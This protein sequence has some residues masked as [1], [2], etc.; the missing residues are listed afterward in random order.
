MS[1]GSTWPA[2]PAGRRRLVARRLDVLRRR[3][4]R[5]GRRRRADCQRRHHRHRNPFQHTHRLRNSLLD[6]TILLA[7]PRS[8]PIRTSLRRRRIRAARRES[9]AQA[10]RRAAAA[11]LAALAAGLAGLVRGPLVGGALLMR[12][13]AAL[14]GDFPLLLRGHR[15]E[16]AA[17]LAFPFLLRLSSISCM[18]ALAGWPAVVRAPHT[19][20][21]RFRRRI[22]DGRRFR[23]VGRRLGRVIRH[24]RGLAGAVSWFGHCIS[25]DSLVR[26]VVSPSGCSIKRCASRRDGPE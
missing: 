25:L 18:V 8:S 15:G 9:S 20:W 22:L 16:A 21:I 23:F 6:P 19:G 26:T 17:F 1:V 4:A 3:P 24:S 2:A 10:S 12:G 13:P 11:D 7:P 5:L 14:A